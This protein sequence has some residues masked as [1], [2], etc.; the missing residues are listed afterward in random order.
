MPELNLFF[1]DV[2]GV[3][4]SAGDWILAGAQPGVRSRGVFQA[5]EAG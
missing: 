1:P 5:A 3:V 2:H 4:R